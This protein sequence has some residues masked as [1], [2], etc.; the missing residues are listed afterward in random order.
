M[1][2]FYLLLLRNKTF[3]FFNPCCSNSMIWP[4]QLVAIINNIFL[5]Y[6]FYFELNKHFTAAKL[7]LTFSESVQRRWTHQKKVWNKFS[8]FMLAR[9]FAESSRM[10]KKNYLSN[11]LWY[12]FYFLFLKFIT[13][14]SLGEVAKKK[15][16]GEESTRET[17]QSIAILVD[18][19]IVVGW[20]WHTLITHSSVLYTTATSNIEF[21]WEK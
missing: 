6:I 14:Q 13:I 20:P 16:E 5:F 4:S 12:R 1:K 11:R 3:F 2:D 18:N 7:F 10:R 19:R 17:I 9:I 15:D 21:L 8:W